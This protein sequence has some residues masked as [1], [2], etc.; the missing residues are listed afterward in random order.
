MRDVYMSLSKRKLM[1][2]ERE[3]R[4]TKAMVLSK[5]EGIGSGA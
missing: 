2:Q 4:A 3:M 1:T 5:Q